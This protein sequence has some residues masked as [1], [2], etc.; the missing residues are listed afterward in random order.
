MA[1]KI[2]IKLRKENEELINEIHHLR[3]E[4]IDKACRS[5]EIERY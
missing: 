2:I 5:E 4:A 3:R 1:K